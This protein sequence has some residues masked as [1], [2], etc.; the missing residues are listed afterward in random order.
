VGVA[1]GVTQVA[2]H[3]LTSMSPLVQ[4]PV[5]SK[6]HFFLLFQSILLYKKLDTFIKEKRNKTL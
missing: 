5:P 6:T 4:S 1:W 3:L 2:E